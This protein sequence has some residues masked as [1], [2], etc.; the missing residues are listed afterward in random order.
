MDRSEL[1]GLGIYV[2]IALPMLHTYLSQV[3]LMLSFLF[4]LVVRD[5]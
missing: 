2:G 1:M 3:V 5:P 4:V